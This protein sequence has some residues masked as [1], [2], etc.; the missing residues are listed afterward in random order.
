M[1]LVYCLK[2]SWYKQSCKNLIFQN[3]VYNITFIFIGSYLKHH[4]KENKNEK[5]IRAPRLMEKYDIS[6]PLL[7]ICCYKVL[8]TVW[9]EI[10]KN[11][12]GI[13]P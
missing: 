8:K 13:I 10:G 7:R 5:C 1:L 12:I 4:Q 2:Y 3:I 11:S 9:A 6:W